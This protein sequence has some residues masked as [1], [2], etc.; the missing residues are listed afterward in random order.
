MPYF[1]SIAFI[2]NPMM[3][4]EAQAW[5]GVTLRGTSRQQKCVPKMKWSIA[6]AVV[7]L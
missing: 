4:H 6:H 3:R 7:Y 2:L 1:Y 5:Y